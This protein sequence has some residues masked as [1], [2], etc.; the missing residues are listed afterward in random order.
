MNK[1]EQL[2]SLGHQILLVRGGLGLGPVQSGAGEGLGACIER[3][4]AS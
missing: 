4:N 1:F 3:S 2:T